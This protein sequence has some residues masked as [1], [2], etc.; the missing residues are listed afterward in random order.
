MATIDFRQ[1]HRT[2]ANDA[3][4]R[5]QGLLDAFG[6]EH[7]ELNIAIVWSADGLMGTTSGRGFKARV[8]ITDDHV[9]IA[10]DL[11]LFVRPLKGRVQSSLERR[12]RAEFGP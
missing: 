12:M 3:S 9:D 6:D 5:T 10:I 7:P 2:D 4:R 1:P 8:S 11:S